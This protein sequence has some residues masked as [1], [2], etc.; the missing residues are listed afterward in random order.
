MSWHLFLHLSYINLLTPWGPI[1]NAS[2]QIEALDELVWNILLYRLYV[3]NFPTH[4]ESERVVLYEL[5]AIA[6][7]SLSLVCKKMYLVCS[8]TKRREWSLL[9]KRT[10][11]QTWYADSTQLSYFVLA[12]WTR[13]DDFSPN[14]CWHNSGQKWYILPSW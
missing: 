8:F 10:F 4:F 6:D 9:L 5:L 3:Q 14:S 2:T 7:C 13:D 12:F 1:R 11:Y